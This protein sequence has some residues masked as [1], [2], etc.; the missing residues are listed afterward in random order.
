M[1][2]KCDYLYKFWKSC[3]LIFFSF[4]VIQVGKNRNKRPCLH[5]KSLR[6]KENAQ[7][8]KLSSVIILLKVCFSCRDKM[9]ILKIISKYERLSKENWKLFLLF[10]L[11]KQIVCLYICFKVFDCLLNK[12]SKLV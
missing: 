12:D 3:L 10:Y 5:K 2:I 11:H 8:H 6:R 7:V 1:L 4:T 9:A